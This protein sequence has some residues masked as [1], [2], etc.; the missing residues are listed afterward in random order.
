MTPIKILF[1]CHGNICRSPMCEFVMKEL[2]RR[3][4]LE[5]EFVIAS[6]ATT[7]EE[8]GH[9][10]HR[11]TRDVLTK[12][13]IP[14]GHRRA[15]QLTREE[16]ADWD[17]IVGMDTENMEDISY[18]VGADTE[19]KVFRLME[20]CGERRDVADPWYTGDFDKTYSD[21]V[22]GCRALLEKVKSESRS[23]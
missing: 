3:E 7:T 2:V 4:G 21:V 17:Y 11:G 18:I 5:N 23:E 16:Y 10:V 13:G 22:R 15:R 1:I 6:A 8:I 20:L 14:F 12:H 9:D 19:H